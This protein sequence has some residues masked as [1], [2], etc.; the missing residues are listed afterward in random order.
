MSAALN[1][2]PD[3]SI[4]STGTTHPDLS[5]GSLNSHFSTPGRNISLTTRIPSV[6]SPTTAAS[7]A[8]LSTSSPPNPSVARRHVQDATT[9]NAKRFGL[10]VSVADHHEDE[11]EDADGDVLDT[12][13]QDKRWGGDVAAP[14]RPK[15]TRSAGSKVTNNLTLRDQ[16][17][18]N[19]SIHS[20][21]WKVY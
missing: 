18:V 16:E 2:A 4:Q 11:G 17:K 8:P 14:G 7:S 6:S 13:G 15:R 12:P 21:H 20:M 9:P 19:R 3:T 5:L 1:T 10:G